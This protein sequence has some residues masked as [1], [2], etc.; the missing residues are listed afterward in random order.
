MTVSKT[1]IDTL[2]LDMRSIILS[3]IDAS[4]FA[5]KRREEDANRILKDVKDD[6]VRVENEY[7]GIIGSGLIKQHYHLSINISDLIDFIEKIKAG[8]DQEE[9]R[10]KLED[11]DNQLEAIL[12]EHFAKKTIGEIRQSY[13]SL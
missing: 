4:Y 9:V 2:V 8:G 1:M 6:L 10:N 5:G 12:G 3:L 11:M 7:F 13:I